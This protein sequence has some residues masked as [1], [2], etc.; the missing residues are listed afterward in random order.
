MHI[1]KHV[2]LFLVLPGDRKSY[3][4]EREGL[5]PGKTPLKLN[6]RKSSFRQTDRTTVLPSLNK[7]THAGK[8]K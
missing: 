4:P 1:E 8:R 2:C 6:D 3:L 7:H 5:S